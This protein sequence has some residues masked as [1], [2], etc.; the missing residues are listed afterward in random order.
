MSIQQHDVASSL[1]QICLTKILEIKR[2]KMQINTGTSVFQNK[3]FENFC[4]LQ[5]GSVIAFKIII[6]NIINNNMT[7][8][9]QTVVLNADHLTTDKENKRSTGMYR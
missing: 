1:V 4:H 9:G 5:S 6:I 7:T 3:Y 8:Y 2:S